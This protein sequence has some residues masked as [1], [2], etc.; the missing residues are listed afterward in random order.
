MV[1]TTFTIS[2]TAG[3]VYG[4][5][6][7]FTNT[8]TSINLITN[9]VWDFGDGST[10]VFDVNSVSH[11]YTYPGTYFIGLTAA[12]ILGNAGVATQSIKVDYIYRD[13]IVVTQI[14]DDYATPGLPTPNTFKITLT[15]AQIDRPLNL[16]LYSANSRSTPYETVP[17][18]WRFLTPTWR[19]LDKNYTPTTI[20]S[21]E[22]VPLYD[23]SRVVGVSGE[24]EFY[25]VDDQCTGATDLPEEKCPLLITVTLE[26]S[27]F[28]YSN[29]SKVYSYPGFANNKA[30]RA[31]I[32]WDVYGNIPTYLNITGNYLDEIYKY[33]WKDV[34]IP[35]LITTQSKTKNFLFGS[36][37]VEPTILF[38]YPATNEFGRISAVHI[39]LSGTNQY[40]VDEAPLYFQATDKD[41]NNTGG[42]IFS[43]ITPLTTMDTTV[44]VAS[45]MLHI[46]QETGTDKFTFPVGC[47]PNAIGWVS[48][49]ANKTISKIF[50]P[51]Y[52]VD[53]RTINEFRSTGDLIDGYIKTI[54]VPYIESNSTYNYYMSGF[55]G[56]YGMAIDPRSNNLL[57]T[58]AEL[59]RVYKFSTGGTLLCSVEIS[60][61]GGY[62]SVSGAYTPSNICIDGEFNVYASLF[63]SVSVLKFD[64]NL[65]YL[66][67]LVPSPSVSL[68]YLGSAVYFNNDGLS[69]VTASDYDGFSYSIFDLDIPDG[70]FLNKPATVET[71][72]D[73]NV[74]V[75]YSNPLYSTLVKFDSTGNVIFEYP[76][77]IGASPVSLAVTRENNLWVANSYNI[78]DNEGVLELR[79]TSGNIL[80][81][82]N[83][84]AHPTYTTM[85]KYNNLWF[86]FGTRYLG[87]ISKLG[88]LSAWNI[89]QDGTITSMTSSLIG[90]GF[91]TGNISTAAPPTTAGYVAA[92]SDESIFEDE[93]IGGLTIDGF[94]RVWLL[95]SQQN[96]TH[97][98][99]ALPSDINRNIKRTFKVIPDSTL[100]Y[101][102]DDTDSYTYT[103]TGSYYKSLQANGDWTGNR[104][105]QKHFNPNALTA[106]PVSGISA[107]FSINDFYNSGEFRRVN[108]SFNTAEHY[109]SLALPEALNRNTRFFDDF[110][111]AVVGNAQLS[112]SDDIGQITYE[113]IANFVFNH[114]DIDTCSIPQLLSYANETMVP[115]ANFSQTFPVDIAKYLDFASVARSKTFGLKSPL[116]ILRKS[117]GEVLNTFTDYVTAGQKIFLQNKFDT[118]EYSLIT[119]PLLN[120]QTVYPLSSINVPGF[121]QSIIIE[122]IFYKYSPVFSDSYI[123]NYIDWNSPF[124]TLKPY[125]SSESEW[126]GDDG[127][128]EKTFNYL[129]T[130]NIVVK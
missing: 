23:N 86:I 46:P 122:Y 89:G 83:D 48:N 9:Q 121:T 109:K 58:D 111:G 117:V 1:N 40:V 65:N 31:G 62:S 53:C 49:P 97:V 71:D 56:I 28:T 77:P 129:L 36:E 124:T 119:I 115:V 38:S 100:G 7:T 73:N 6:F 25:Y 41:N 17:T 76:L 118:T 45:A 78:T 112:G 8:T 68:Y 52:S 54:N 2:P 114:A 11:I 34:K 128:I 63:N 107:P 30:I 57:A 5:E 72:R 44:I 42:Y 108:E 80:S 16:T 61:I 88:Q 95:D 47:T 91:Y 67:S 84:F 126:L 105:Y 21:V 66:Y 99:N 33:K 12:D 3:N 20:L 18:K 110:L 103:E 92:T 27:G 55:A 75:A 106:V 123:E 4:T 87:Y 85:D 81:S 14:P 50:Y 19:F 29:D 10:R 130:K 74:W 120:N 60:A 90:K 51:P 98:F 39:S 32:I 94:N 79:D 22:P 13:K 64:D 102:L 82:Y 116:P 125:L 43:T 96:L 26:T 59:D 93:E 69:Y 113:K 15:S 101:Y 35:F 127:I 24:T 70:D 37:E 104:W